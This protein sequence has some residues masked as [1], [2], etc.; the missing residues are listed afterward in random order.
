MTDNRTNTLARDL[1]DQTSEDANATMMIVKRADV[2][3]LIAVLKFY[4][5]SDNWEYDVDGLHMFAGAFDGDTV[6]EADKGKRAEAL[7]AR[8]E[9]E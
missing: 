5:N 6:I 8:L 3:E 2:E 7:L 4:A 1:H 9:G